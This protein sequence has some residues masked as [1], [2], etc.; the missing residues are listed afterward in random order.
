MEQHLWFVAQEEFSLDCKL[1]QPLYGLK[2]SAQVWFT[3]F[4]HCAN[5]WIETK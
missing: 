5:F 4:S 3:K 1:H 2:Q